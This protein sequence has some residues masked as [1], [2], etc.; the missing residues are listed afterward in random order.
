[1]QLSVQIQNNV[2]AFVRVWHVWSPNLVKLRNLDLF[3]ILIAKASH[4]RPPTLNLYLCA[5]LFLSYGPGR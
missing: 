5:I 2:I 1:M 3:Y 4:D